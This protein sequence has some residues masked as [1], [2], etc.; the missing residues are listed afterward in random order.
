MGIL[1]LPFKAAWK[2]L[3]LPFAIAGLVTKVL[4]LAA[5]AGVV[6]ALIIILIT[7]S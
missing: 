5:V 4:T 3:T 2:I 6:A 1:M 7:L